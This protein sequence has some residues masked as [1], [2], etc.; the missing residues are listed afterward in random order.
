[1]SLII[2]VIRRA[3]A[4]LLI[5]E[6]LLTAARMTSML[7]VLAVYDGVALLL[8]V[9][10]ALLVPL[11]FAGGWFV[12]SRRPQGPPLARA[13]LVLGAVLTVFDVG[14]GLAP[15]PI[16]PCWRWQATLAYAIYAVLG[17]LVMRSGEAGS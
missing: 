14:L 1:M 9:L 5:A 3:V 15:S 11:Q 7:S 16:Y 2:P 10:R 8:I 17:V 13:A 6:S 12:A 4:F